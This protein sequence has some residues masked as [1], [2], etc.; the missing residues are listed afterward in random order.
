MA[1][2]GSWPRMNG[3]QDMANIDFERHNCKRFKLA[4]Y[5]VHKASGMPLEVAEEALVDAINRGKVRG[6]RHRFDRVEEIGSYRNVSRPVD[7]ETQVDGDQLTAWIAAEFSPEPA[8]ACDQ[9][10]EHK[11]CAVSSAFHESE[12]EELRRVGFV[13]K[14]RLM[15]DIR[16]G[17]SHYLTDWLPWREAVSRVVIASRMPVDAAE[18]FLIEYANYG[19]LRFEVFSLQH[20]GQ[21]ISVSNKMFLHSPLPDKLSFDGADL[22]ALIR[23]HFGNDHNV[24]QPMDL[25]ARCRTWLSEAMRRSPERSPMKKSRWLSEAQQ[26]FHGLAKRAFDRAWPAAIRD[27]GA[28]WDRSGRKP[29][30]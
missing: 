29:S 26:L 17:E 1:R 5:E 25:E 28:K 7:L 19:R 27:T 11:R 15:T 10:L 3:M 9:G 24:S 30:Q 16:T 13:V 23:D 21:G 18:G 8:T 20:L 14:G 2:P 22:A 12:C 4:V 6:W